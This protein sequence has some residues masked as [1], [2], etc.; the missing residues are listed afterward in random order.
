MAKKLEISDLY[1]A[2]ASLLSE[3]Q[4]TA[5][6]LYYNEDLSLSEIAEQTGI[7][8]QG[9]RDRIKH[10]ESF[11]LFYEEKLHLCEKYQKTEEI[12]SQ[13]EKN[14]DKTGKEELCKY[15]AELRLVNE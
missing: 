13:M 4:S 6:D 9:V 7:S 5:L 10:G 11:L 3:E 12:L 2:Y 15:I 8:R 1:D 14:A